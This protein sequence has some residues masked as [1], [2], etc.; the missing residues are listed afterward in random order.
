MLA[1]FFTMVIRYSYIGTFNS[2]KSIEEGVIPRNGYC[3]GNPSCQ[4]L[5]P[6]CKFLDFFLKNVRSHICFV[7]FD[8]FF[9]IINMFLLSIKSKVFWYVSVF[10][11]CILTRL[12]RTCWLSDVSCV[13]GNEWD[14]QLC[15]IW[16]VL[17]YCFQMK[18]QPCHVMEMFET[19]HTPLEKWTGI[20]VTTIPVIGNYLAYLE[21][22]P[23]REVDA[24]I[25]FTSCC[26]YCVKHVCVC[27]CVTG[28]STVTKPNKRMA[29]EMMGK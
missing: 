18:S 26:A 5:F 12:K 1:L 23:E 14:P 28:F 21:F 3:F 22:L 20:K 13:A 16:R 4:L 8:V 15:N 6:S 7:S 24:F 11:F 25:I 9:K 2:S 19:C 27:I 29:K 10:L 17:R